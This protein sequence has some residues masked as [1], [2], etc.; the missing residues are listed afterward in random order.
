MQAPAGPPPNAPVEALLHGM[1]RRRRRPA[2]RGQRR[3]RN[4]GWG[5]LQWGC[6]HFAIQLLSSDVEAAPKG[7]ALQSAATAAAA[8]CGERCC[9]GLLRHPTGSAA[10]LDS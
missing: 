6:L 9:L 3:R 1:R 10:R 7:G 5:I 4:R 2:C 8:S